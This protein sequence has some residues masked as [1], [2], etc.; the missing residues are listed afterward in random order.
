MSEGKQRFRTEVVVALIGLIGVLGAAALANW[1]KIFPPDVEREPRPTD[2]VGSQLEA[3]TDTVAPVAELEAPAPKEPECGSTISR[4]PDDGSL[5]LTWES[6]EGAS[7]YTVEADCFDC[8]EFERTWYSLAAGEPWHI[9]GGLGLRSPRY[10][11]EV[12][13]QLREA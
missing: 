8:R 11:S 5:S 10:T 6:V 12:H 3:P 4:P 9:R 1:D 2:E 7:T 13:V